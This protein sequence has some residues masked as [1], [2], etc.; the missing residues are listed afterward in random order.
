[1][2]LAIGTEVTK[3]QADTAHFSEARWTLLNFPDKNGDSATKNQFLATER[4]TERL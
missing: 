1:M 4:E 3:T 2:T